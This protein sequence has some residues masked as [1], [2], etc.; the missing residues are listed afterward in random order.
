MQFCSFTVAIRMFAFSGS[1]LTL[2]IPK[3]SQNIPRSASS[4]LHGEAVP[5]SIQLTF[6]TVSSKSFWHI[7]K[8]YDPRNLVLVEVSRPLPRVIK[9]KPS[10]IV[11]SERN[12]SINYDDLVGPEHEL[13]G[14]ENSDRSLPSRV[15]DDDKYSNNDF[16]GV[17]PELHRQFIISQK[18]RS[19]H[20][21]RLKRRRSKEEQESLLTETK[22]DTTS[23]EVMEN[24]ITFS[25][26]QV[27]VSYYIHLFLVKPSFTVLFLLRY[28]CRTGSKFHILQLCTE[29]IPIY[30]FLYSFFYL[31]TETMRCS[32]RTL[33]IQM[34]RVSDI[35]VTTFLFHDLN[36]SQV[37]L[38]LLSQ[39]S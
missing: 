21:S 19:V 12:G 22:Q 14:Y 26:E 36:L 6:Q 1:V 33:T 17:F 38:A 15:G 13:F 9:H 24:K 20:K 32:V 30:N 37:K 2:P 35:T 5:S 10:S 11:F 31:F 27:R 8:L 18:R 29:I 34:H 16:S 4:H 23:T 25:E 3:N 28:V 7:S 39:K